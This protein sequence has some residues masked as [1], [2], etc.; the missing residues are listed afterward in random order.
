M[1]TERLLL[2]RASD[3]VVLCCGVVLFLLFLDIFLQ[4]RWAF[5]MG[6]SCAGPSAR[7][8]SDAHLRRVAYPGALGCG[9]QLVVLKNDDSIAESQC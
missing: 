3:G 5:G 7:L 9:W 6:W 2:W 4:G 8:Y 1:M